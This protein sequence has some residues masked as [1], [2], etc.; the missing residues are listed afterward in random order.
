M[1]VLISKMILAELAGGVAERFEQTGDRRH[2]VRDPMRRARHA[3]RDQSRADGML[4]EMYL[5]LPL[6]LLL[7][8]EET[9]LSVL[10]SR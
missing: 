5:A 2:S 1:L 9:S 3:D 6:N 8:V 7:F 4:A 10:G